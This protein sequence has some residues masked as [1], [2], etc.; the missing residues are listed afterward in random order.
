MKILDLEQQILNLW[1]IIDDLRDI[2]NFVLEDPSIDIQPPEGYDK[3]ANLLLGI[4]SLYQMKFERTWSTFEEV[5]REYHFYRKET[6]EDHD[7]TEQV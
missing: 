1:N 4:Q 5:C 6:K 2:N 7:Y 3:I